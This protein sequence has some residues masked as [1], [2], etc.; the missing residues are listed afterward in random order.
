LESSPLAMSAPSSPDT[1]RQ[2]IRVPTDLPRLGFIGEDRESVRHEIAGIANEKVW[3]R[4]RGQMAWPVATVGARRVRRKRNR[5]RAVIPRMGSPLWSTP[6]A[7]KRLAQFTLPPIG[8]TE[9]GVNSYTTTWALIKAAPRK[10]S[11]RRLS[12]YSL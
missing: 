8:P 1:P 6:L 12:C 2:E 4:W 11:A 5:R 7:A 3:R 10:T 9:R